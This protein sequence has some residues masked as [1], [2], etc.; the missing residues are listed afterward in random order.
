MGAT[1]GFVVYAQL[2]DHHHQAYQ[3]EGRQ[4]NK[5]KGQPIIVYVK[6]IF[7]AVDY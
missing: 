2:I 3:I 5:V 1:M 7:V 6:H 4:V